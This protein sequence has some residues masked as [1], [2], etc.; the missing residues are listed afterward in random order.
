MAKRKVSRAR[1]SS[2]GSSRSSSDVFGIK[3]DSLTF[4]LFAVFVLVVALIAVSR[5]L[6]MSLY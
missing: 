5:M 4:F 6:G 2:S 1:R 3:F